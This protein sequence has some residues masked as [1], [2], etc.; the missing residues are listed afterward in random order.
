MHH[1]GFD[2]QQ[3]NVVLGDA[4]ENQVWIWLEIQTADVRLRQIGSP[5]ANFWE[6]LQKPQSFLQR[7]PPFPDDVVPK[8][9]RSRFGFVLE[10]LQE[11]GRV[12]QPHA[13][14]FSRRWRARFT[15][16]SIAASS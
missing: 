8:F 4:V 11:S 12:V 5:P 15:P 7:L 13:P 3:V 14:T 16:R 6:L 2:P 1:A 10:V 9:F